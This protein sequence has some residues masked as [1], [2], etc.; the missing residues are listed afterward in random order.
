MPS[1]KRTGPA[2]RTRSIRAL[3]VDLDRTLMPSRGGSF[4]SASRTLSE[5]RAMGL[6]VI[7]VSGREYPTL[8]SI[9]R[10]IGMVDAV[11]AENGALVDSPFRGNPKPFGAAIGR[12]VR[13]RFAAT[14]LRGVELGTVVVSVPRRSSAE[15]GRLV[16]G[17]AVR[18][19]KN[20]DRVM[21][22]PRGVDKATGVRAAM[23]GLRL[24]EGSFAAIGDGENDLPLLRAAALSGAVHNA[25]VAVRADSDYVCRAAVGA[26]VREFVRGPLSVRNSLRPR[27]G[28]TR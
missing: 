5:V 21:I 12:Q 8:A 26:G 25:R 11:V 1:A 9:A 7:L 17:L 23:R 27:I 6:R 10:R 18:L 13:E 24:P 4:A 16:A 3:A 15:A 14:R 2:Q 28:R 20:V 19:V 22:L